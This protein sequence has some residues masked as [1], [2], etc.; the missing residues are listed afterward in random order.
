[1]LD[2]VFQ[3]APCGIDR[4]SKEAIVKRADHCLMET[5]HVFGLEL[6]GQD[7]QSILLPRHQILDAFRVVDLYRVIAERRF[8]AGPHA[9]EQTVEDPHDRA[10]NR[11][12]N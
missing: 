7:V 6:A 5:L 1:L 3:Q 4:F 9:A 11:Q 8:S 12:Q 10:G 2:I